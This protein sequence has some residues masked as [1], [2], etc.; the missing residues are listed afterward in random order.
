[1]YR[2]ILNI[3]ALR[4]LE[5]GKKTLETTQILIMKEE[6]VYTEVISSQSQVEPGQGL[7]QVH[8]G[9]YH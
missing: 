4:I 9:I 5:L 1:M 2:N 3:R 7:L 8:A 6:L